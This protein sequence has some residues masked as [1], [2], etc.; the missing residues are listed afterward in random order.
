MVICIKSLQY[1]LDESKKIN[2]NISIWFF[3]SEHVPLEAKCKKT[4]PGP[5]CQSQRAFGSSG[6]RLWGWSWTPICWE[7]SSLQLYLG[8]VWGSLIELELGIQL[9]TWAGYFVESGGYISSC[10]K[11]N[12]DWQ[13]QFRDPVG[14][15]HSLI[16]VDIQDRAKAAAQR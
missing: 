13:Y 9:C 15:D 10:A 11:N 5:P 16:L 2:Q 8:F 3:F 14:D 1:S 6:R 7:E 4:Q 12:P